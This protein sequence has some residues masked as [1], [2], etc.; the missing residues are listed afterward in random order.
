VVGFLKGGEPLQSEEEKGEGRAGGR[1]RREG[2]GV[3]RRN[4]KAWKYKRV[5][6]V[7]SSNGT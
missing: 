7:F 3:E 4:I 1:G 2:G 6:T 5:P